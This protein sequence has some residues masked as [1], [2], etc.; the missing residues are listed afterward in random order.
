MMEFLA[1]D[2]LRGRA[3]YTAGQIRAAEFIGGQF[4]ACGLQPFINGKGFYYPFSPIG[5]YPKSANPNMIT[6][7]GTTLSKKQFFYSNPLPEVLPMQLSDFRMVKA[8]QLVNNDSAEYYFNDHL[9]LLIWSEKKQGSLPSNIMERM[10]KS[11]HKKILYVEHPSEPRQLTIHAN[12]SFINRVLYNVAAVIPGK[13]RPREL[14]FITAHYDHIDVDENGKRGLYNG[15][16]DNASGVTALLQLA[17]Y[18]SQT[19]PPERTMVFVAF[20]GEE[21]GLTG[22]KVFVEKVKPSQVVCQ[23]N[24]EMIGVYRPTYDNTYFFTGEQ[25]SDLAK[26]FSENLKGTG[27]VKVPEQNKRDDLFLRS[28]N[29]PFYLKGIPAHSIMCIGDDDPCLHQEC[30]DADR[31]DYVHM[32]NIIRAIAVG[33]STIVNGTATP[34]LK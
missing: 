21:L 10:N 9:P 24:I 18:F 30:D 25:Y 29:L 19:A 16:N 5:D 26:I 7:N 12:P 27:I 22:S 33:L 23:L 17:R 13:S 32:N 14:V 6:C 3:N 8:E 4:K 11:D 2:K 28:D 15:A 20:A 34:V 1:S 31:I